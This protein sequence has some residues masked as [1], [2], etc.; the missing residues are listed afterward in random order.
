MV[1]TRKHRYEISQKTQKKLKEKK[2]KQRKVQ[3]NGIRA[4]KLQS[5]TEKKSSKPSIE[6]LL[7]LC[8][9]LSIRLSRCVL[10]DEATTYQTSK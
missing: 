1:N 2:Q 3:E 6:D 10:R 4:K 5:E 9:P 8:R 7:K